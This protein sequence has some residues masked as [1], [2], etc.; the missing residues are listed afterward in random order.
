MPFVINGNIF[1]NHNIMPFLTQGHILSE[2]THIHSHARTHRGFTTQTVT[3]LDKPIN[4]RFNF[5][6]YV[7]S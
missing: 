3:V 2:H 7:H 1:D 5:L 6:P 4:N